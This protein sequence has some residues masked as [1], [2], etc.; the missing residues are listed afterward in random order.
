[1]SRRGYILNARTEERKTFEVKV[2][3]RKALLLEF[4]YLNNKIY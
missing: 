2:I 4:D 3:L 1:M